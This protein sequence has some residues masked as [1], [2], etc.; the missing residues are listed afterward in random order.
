LSI[1][2]QLTARFSARESPASALAKWRATHPDWLPD[3]YEQIDESYNSI[4]WE[5]RHT[6]MSMKFVP[7]GAALGGR[8]VYRLTALFQAD[9]AGG[10]RITVNGS[11]DQDT[12]RAIHAATTDL[13]EGGVP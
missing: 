4:T 8:T 13:Q 3:H 10:S 12:H 2:A 6:P 11:C 5:W 1:S 7:F 9:G